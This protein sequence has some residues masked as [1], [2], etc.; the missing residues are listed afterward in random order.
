MEEKE[1]RKRRSGGEGHLYICDR[2]GGGG[3]GNNHGS[4]TLHAGNLSNNENICESDFPWQIKKKVG[5]RP[6][7]EWG[8]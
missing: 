1:E 5:V 2:L 3:I 8:I 4:G 7:V 6:S